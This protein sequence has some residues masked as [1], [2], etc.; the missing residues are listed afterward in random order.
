[1]TALDDPPASTLDCV[2][3]LCPTTGDCCPSLQ[4]RKQCLKDSS[5]Q[6]VRKG[7]QRVGLLSNHSKFLGCL[8]NTEAVLLHNLL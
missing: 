1:M 5:L 6:P 3:A 7:A 2:P 8:G 4:R